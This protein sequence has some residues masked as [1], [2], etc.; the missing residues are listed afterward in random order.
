M[1]HPV[2][3]SEMGQLHVGEG[4]EGRPCLGLLASV[5]HCMQL[6]G[7]AAAPR[8]PAL[9][10][11]DRK[12]A[13]PALTKQW[14]ATRVRALV[15]LPKTLLCL[16]GS[17]ETRGLAHTPKVPT[18]A[19]GCWSTFQVR[20]EDPMRSAGH[21]AQGQGHQETPLPCCSD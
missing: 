15:T 17:L 5:R 21:S 18:W 9:S 16:L 3:L 8:E 13:Q 11:A 7:P 12:Q 6:R 10:L 14:V 19:L 2:Y 20:C 1:S 4:R